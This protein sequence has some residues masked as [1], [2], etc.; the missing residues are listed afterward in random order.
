[1]MRRRQFITLLGGAAA[2][3]IAARAQSAAEPVVGYLVPGSTGQNAHLLPLVR[4]ALAEVG[5]VEGRN[6][7]IEYRYAEGQY[8]RLPALGR[9]W[10]RRQ[11]GAAGPATPL[12]C[13]SSTTCSASSMTRGLRV[14]IAWPHDGHQHD[15]G[16]GLALSMQYKN[17]GANMLPRHAINH[18][19]NQNNIEPA[20]EEMRQLWYEA[21]MTIAPH[22]GELLEELRYYHREENFRIVK[23]RD[24]LVSPLRYA[25]M[26]VEIL[27]RSITV[28]RSAILPRKRAEE[29]HRHEI[30]AS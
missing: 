28:L 2:W 11:P 12:A 3:P 6:L 8:D 15:K 1:M 13:T 22:N 18:G 25:I 7:T 23:Q 21:K 26:R 17:L 9:R 14:P 29:G 19:T 10:S 24:D 27:R 5:Y 30:S 20:L 4:Q 16:S